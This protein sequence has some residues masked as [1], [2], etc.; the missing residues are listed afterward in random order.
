M[1]TKIR[2]IGGA[3]FEGESG[4][5]HKIVMDGPPDG[6]GRDLG[7][8]PMETLL[9]G[10]GACTAYDVV[11]ILQKSRQDIRDCSMTVSANRADEH[12]RVF[13]DIHIHFIVSGRAV[14]EKQV[15]RAIKL[16]AEK[17]CSASIM[18]GKTA[19]ITH[20]FEIVEAPE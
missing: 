7:P 3:A 5:G 1:E 12:P 11:S 9:L 14:S 15:E 2:W 19:K 20:D 16:S 17:Y 13:I 18:L 10:M 8:R 6:G 4:E